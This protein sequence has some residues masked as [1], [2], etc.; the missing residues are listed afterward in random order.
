MVENHLDLGGAVV[1]WSLADSS[2][3]HRLQSG[4]ARLGLAEMVPDPRP[5]SAVLRDALEEILGGRQTLVRPL[6]ARD[7]FTVVREDRGVTEN[8]YVTALVARVI[9]EPPRL[10]FD[11]DDDRADRVRQAYQ[12][13]VDRIPAGQLSAALVRIVEGLGGTRL[14]PSGAVYWVPGHRLAEWAEIATAVE[15]SATGRP[16]AVYAIRHR[17][18]A[19]AVRAVRDAVVAEV[20]AEAQRIAA[21]VATGELG[22]RALETRQKEAADLRNKVLLYE[23]LLSLGLDGLHL[24]VDRADQA[25]AGASLLLAAQTRFEPISVAE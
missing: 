11:P 2:D 17:L 21:D 6:A 7:G 18:D 20:T 15:Q 4:L 14:R 22:S 12:R 23:E 9:G 10:R 8:S 19:E 5:A 24:A 13:H 3:R 1:F 25:A 16:S